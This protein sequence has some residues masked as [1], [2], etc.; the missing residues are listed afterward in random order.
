[1]ST[2]DH[3]PPC[4]AGSVC[5]EPAHCP[6]EDRPA[7]DVEGIARVLQEHTITSGYDWNEESYSHCRCGA[8]DVG[9]SHQA[10]AVAAYLAGESR[11]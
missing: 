1:M 10:A 9:P 8:E 11:G 5:G 3:R 7:V 2:T 4:I 6:P